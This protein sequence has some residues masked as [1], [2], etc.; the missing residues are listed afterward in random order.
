[1]VHEM[2][3]AQPD[4]PQEVSDYWKGHYPGIKTASE[5]LEDISHG[6]YDL[7]GYFTLPENAWWIEYYG[8][9][10][11]HIKNLRVKYIGD[12]KALNTLNNEQREIETSKRYREWYGSAFFVMQKS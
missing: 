11:E 3:W 12:S 5:N 8:P 1:M 6:G 7:I 10:K 2:T 9:L 4:P